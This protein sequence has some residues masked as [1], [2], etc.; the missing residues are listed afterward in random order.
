MP[1]ARYY[2][3]AK[4]FGYKNIVRLTADNPFTD[5]E[6]MDNLIENHVQSGADYSNQLAALPYGVGC[7]IFTF[8]SLEESAR[9][10][11]K[12]S[13]LEYVSEYI[14]DNP[15]KFNINLIADVKKTKNHP[16]IRLTV[17]TPDD[18]KRACYIVEHCN[19]EFVTTEE[20]IRLSLDYASHCAH[21]V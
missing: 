19:D 10:V 7:E 6:E 20:A 12:F 17:D 18:H 4:Q 5:I 2:D 21:S 9:H 14:R 8:A 11:D 15:S 16:N 3:C 13:H 1:V